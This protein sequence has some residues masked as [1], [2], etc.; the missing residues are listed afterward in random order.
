MDED[1]QTYKIPICLLDAIIK[2]A[3]KKIA[4]LVCCVEIVYGMGAKKVFI[5]QVAIQVGIKKGE[6]EAFLDILV[7][8]G[9]MIKEVDCYGF[10]E[11]EKLGDISRYWKRDQITGMIFPPDYKTE[12]IT[13][14]EEEKEILRIL[15]EIKGF[16]KGYEEDVITIKL[17][18]N[19]KEE[20]LTVD[21]RELVKNWVV[22]KQDQPFKKRS[23][24]RAQ[25]RNQ[26]S[27]AS[28]RG[29]FLKSPGLKGEG[30]KYAGKVARYKG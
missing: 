10:V 11:V 6:A 1:N 3:S 14:T 25:L 24:P 27:M 17:L 22:Y 23:S 2:L 20:F 8:M 16:P 4:V 30:R 7:E 19:L 9:V 29:M 28:R 21:V 5:D 18:R 15:S 12:A 26:F 13:I